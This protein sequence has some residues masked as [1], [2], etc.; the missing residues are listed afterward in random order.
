MFKMHVQNSQNIQGMLMSDVLN[1]STV[2]KKAEE[3]LPVDI[4]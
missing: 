3:C 1:L 4:Y 2:K